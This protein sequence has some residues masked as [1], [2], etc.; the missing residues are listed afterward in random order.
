MLTTE[1]ENYPGFVDGILGP[2]LME[3]FRAQAERFG[4]EFLTL[5]ATRVALGELPVRRFGPPTPPQS[6]RRSPVD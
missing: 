2:Q 6:P 5:K 3:R 4:A 1:V